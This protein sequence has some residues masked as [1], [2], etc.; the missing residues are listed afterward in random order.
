MKAM[1]QVQLGAHL[2]KTGAL[3]AEACRMHIHLYAVPE[4]AES[5]GVL[6]TFTQACDALGIAVTVDEE[7]GRI[8]C[9]SRNACWD[10]NH[11]IKNSG[12]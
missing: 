2:V 7:F 8:E 12:T 5:E 3:G 4:R 11:W 6:A 1:G 10:G 9:A